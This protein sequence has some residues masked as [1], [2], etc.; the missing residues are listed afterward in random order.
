M[1]A[2]EVA[3][4]SVD[5]MQQ[6]L[7]FELAVLDLLPGATSVTDFPAGGVAVFRPNDSQANGVRLKLDG[8][9][10]KQTFNIDILDKV[11]A[12]VA[13]KNKMKTQGWA[14]EA[15]VLAA[16]N[17]VRRR[18]Q[19]GTEAAPAA[20]AELTEAEVQWL[21]EWYDSQLEPDSVSIEQANAALAG[22]RA[23]NGGSSAHQALFEAQVIR[24]HTCIITHSLSRA[25]ISLAQPFARARARASL[26]PSGT[27]RP[28]PNL[29]TRLQM[30]L[31]S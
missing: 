30:L 8:R 27:R 16:E 23:S 12:A 4:P 17:Q 14:G 10:V 13:L 9:L 2:A 5:E 22:Y 31:E 24:M 11:A 18:G 6:R 25:R 1:D 29:L 26:P 20:A 7:D 15:A 3:P 28:E 21:S 19:H